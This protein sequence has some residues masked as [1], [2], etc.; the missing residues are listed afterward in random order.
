MR[1]SFDSSARTSVGGIDGARVCSGASDAAAAAG[2]HAPKQGWSREEDETIISMVPRRTASNLAW[3]PHRHHRRALSHAPRSLLLCRWRRW[4]SGGRASP[5]RCRAA[6]TT[7]SGTASCVCRRRSAVRASLSAPTNLRATPTCH[8]TAHRSP[9]LASGASA[10]TSIGSASEGSTTGSHRLSCE[11]SVG[12]TGAAAAAVAAAAEGALAVDSKRGDMWTADED[13]KILSGVRSRAPASNPM[14]ARDAPFTSPVTLTS[15]IH[16]SSRLASSGRS[17]PTRCP[18]APPTPSA[19][20]T[21]VAPPGH[22]DHYLQARASRAPIPPATPAISPR[23]PTTICSWLILSTTTGAAAAAGAAA[24]GVAAAA[25]RRRAVRCWARGT[26]VLP[27]HPPSDG[28]YSAGGPTASAAAAA[29]HAA[30]ALAAV[31]GRARRTSPPPFPICTALRSLG[32]FGG[33]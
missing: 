12:A 26:R 1:S 10:R 9:L 15:R 7:P 13:A 30:A 21:C 4:G 18:G 16:R 22:H 27:R 23:P 17:S 20:A 32:R 14:P 29:A 8:P 19:T 24:A 2:R 5:R 11:S 31:P 33:G 6:R 28:A 25:E 3:T